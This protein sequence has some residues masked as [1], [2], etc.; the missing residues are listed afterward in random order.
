M[1]SALDLDYLHRTRLYRPGRRTPESGFC[2]TRW[3]AP[4][5][6]LL[7]AG[8]AFFPCRYTDDGY[9]FRGLQY[10]LGRALAQ[11]AFGHC[12][13]EDEMCGV[14]RAMG[15][16]FLSSELSDAVTVAR[17]QE[18]PRDAAVIAVSAAVFNRALERHRAAVL[19]VGDGGIVFRY[20]FLTAPV[21]AAD[22][23]R[24][25]VPAGAQLS[26]CPVPADRVSVVGGGGRRELEDNLRS[27][28]ERCGLVPAEPRPSDHYPR[29]WTD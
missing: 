26:G 4:V 2:S 23:A 11:G 20:P 15:V 9:L 12:N 8:Y 3:A 16:Y 1:P 14:E 18:Q 29:R 25:F 24:V 17:L 6:Q 19:A 22:V 21:S 27:E 10:G 5:D 7:A 13:G 28:L